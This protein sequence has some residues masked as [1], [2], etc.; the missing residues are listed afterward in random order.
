MHVIAYI[1]QNM[2]IE[3]REIY[4]YNLKAN[5]VDADLDLWGLVP[6]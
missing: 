1:L 4:I 6:A 2:N 3:Y 5:G